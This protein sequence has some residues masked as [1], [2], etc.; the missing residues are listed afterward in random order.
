MAFN[1]TAGGSEMFLLN[2]CLG[3]PVIRARARSVWGAGVGAGW[4][5]FGVPFGVWGVLLEVVAS[6]HWHGF[7]ISGVYAG[8]FVFWNSRLW[9]R[10]FS[11]QT[12]VNLFI[13]VKKQ[14]ILQH[15]HLEAHQ[16]MP[17]L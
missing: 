15:G 5:L 6:N 12:G 11:L 4:V 17:C 10:V 13:T 3:V 2:P 8:V 7:A 16:L 14:G 1:I 9:A